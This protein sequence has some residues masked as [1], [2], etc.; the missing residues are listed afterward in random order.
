MHGLDTPYHRVRRWVTR[1]LRRRPNARRPI[2]PMELQQLL[3]ESGLQWQRTIQVLPGLSEA[4]LVVATP[5]PFRAEPCTRNRAA[6]TALGV[7]SRMP[8]VPRIPP[9]CAAASWRR[10][11]SC[12][13][14][15][16]RRARKRCGMLIGMRDL[17]RLL[18]SATDNPSHLRKPPSLLGVPRETPLL[19]CLT[20]QRSVGTA[21]SK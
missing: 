17:H 9:L 6:A 19:V 11:N 8:L 14:A 12:S 13:L 15:V 21:A 3:K 10:C 1:P 20:A 18:N 7:P 2:S 4:V 16:A 5:V